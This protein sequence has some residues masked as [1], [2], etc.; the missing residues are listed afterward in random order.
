[1]EG[2]A[3]TA[4][5]TNGPNLN[6]NGEKEIRIIEVHGQS[7]ENTTKRRNQKKND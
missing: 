4:T 3:K 1:M 5:T 2:R 6:D 7:V